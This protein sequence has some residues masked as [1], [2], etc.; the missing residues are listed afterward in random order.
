MIGIGIGIGISNTVVPEYNPNAA[1]FIAAE[2]AAGATF[3]TQQK[4]AINTL[5]ITWDAGGYYSR[6]YPYL[7]L[8]GTAATA[9]INAR[10][11]N[12]G[13]FA[14]SGN[15]FTGSNYST[16]GGG[17]INSKFTTYED[18]NVLAAGKYGYM[19]SRKNVATGQV[20]DV[21]ATTLLAVWAINVNILFRDRWGSI[22]AWDINDGANTL[23]AGQFGANFTT[24][25][26]RYYPAATAPSQFI[27]PPFGTVALPAD[28]IV[29]GYSGAVGDCGVN[30]YQSLI[31]TSDLS[32]AEYE[33][34]RASIATFNTNYGK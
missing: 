34:L 7:F 16:G 25:G 1:A 6:I 8:G 20:T 28:K 15:S 2:E 4:A 11:L 13:T 29:L 12:S 27:N 32:Y 21:I 26:V 18:A 22:G 9:A 23:L 5:F 19:V 10:T 30:E 3:T 31:L 14:G 33:D 24:G 17:A